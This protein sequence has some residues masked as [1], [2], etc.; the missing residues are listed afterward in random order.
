MSL[1][2]DIV[3]FGASAISAPL[4]IG[5]A[6]LTGAVS[7]SSKAITIA[8]LSLLGP[9]TENPAKLSHRPMVCR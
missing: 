3:E 7:A 5:W 6:R 1:E 8:Q 4:D 9:V 2:S